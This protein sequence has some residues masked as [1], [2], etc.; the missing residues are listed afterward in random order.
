MQRPVQVRLRGLVTSFR[1]DIA[2]LFDAASDLSNFE[3]SRA[4]DE[5]GCQFLDF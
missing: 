5:I 1:F 2:F 4:V 3:G